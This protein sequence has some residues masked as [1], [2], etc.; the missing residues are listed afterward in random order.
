MAEK[1]TIGKQAFAGKMAI[2]A[3]GSK[4]I[5]KATAKK[6]FQLGGSVC[7]V[8]RDPEF[9]EKA[10]AEIKDV[11][12]NQD[13]YVETI[14]AD[15]TNMTQ[16]K[17][18]LTEIIEKHGVPDYLINCVGY[19]YPQYVEK[20]T[21]E[22]F[23]KQMD[24][25]YYGQLVPILVVLPY[26]MERK[27]GYIANTSSMLG[28][29]GFIGYACYTPTKF[30]IMGLTDTL[31]HELKPHNIKFSVCCPPDTKTPGFDIE[32]QTKPQECVI[33]SE[34]VKVMEAEEVAEE[35]VE[36][37][38]NEEFFIM[39]GEVKSVWESF[40]LNPEGAREDLDK[41]LENALKRMG[42]AEPDNQGTPSH[43]AV[44]REWDDSEEQRS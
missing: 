25:N 32:N 10:A 44:R 5:G 27:R 15:T 19:A 43:Q 33:V 4:G 7:I 17:P 16:L 29:F 23:R 28:F 2:V 6:I 11:Q 1:K 31:R 13:Q 22:D 21:L 35:F 20:L 40:R 9:L 8:A 41:D 12:V 42:K 34:G 26:F 24:V 14:S 36:G 3:G 39:P 37:I 18:L 38:L 30:A